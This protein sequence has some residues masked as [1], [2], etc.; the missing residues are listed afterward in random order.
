MS[1]L[2]ELR[3][4][5]APAPEAGGTKVVDFSNEPVFVEDAQPVRVEVPGLPIWFDVRPS[6][7]YGVSSGRTA[8]SKQKQAF[9]TDGRKMKPSNEVEITY[10]VLGLFL[11]KVEHCVVGFSI[12]DPKSGKKLT[13]NGKGPH[14]RWCFQQIK[15]SKV[16]EWI[17]E[18]I[19]RIVGWGEEAE[20]ETEQFPQ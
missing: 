20:Q 7:D 2:D 18:Q 1:K 5:T 12:E 8:F 15:S 16:C 4:T 10:D 19:D 14:T 13:Y 3:E 17:G 11:Y 9:V 6:V